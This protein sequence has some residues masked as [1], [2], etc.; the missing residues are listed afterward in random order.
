MN[1]PGFVYVTYIA[2]SPNKVWSA[3]LDGE[4]TKR[5]W[6]HLNVSDWK[7]G[8]RWEHQRCDSRNVDI[9]GTV[10]ECSPPH[11]LVLTWAL[12]QV[13]D[14]ATKVSRV[15]FEIESYKTNMVRLTVVHDDLEADSKMEHGISQGWPMVLSGLKTLLETGTALPMFS[16]HS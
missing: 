2:S 14:D 3:L 7:V 4:M 1:K 11:R 5:Y 15:T 13:M 9:A 12:P 10:V 8:S 16:Q 6:D